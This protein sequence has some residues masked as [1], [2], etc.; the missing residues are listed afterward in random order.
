MNKNF[1]EFQLLG[2]LNVDTTIRLFGEW[3]KGW[4]TIAAD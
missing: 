2:Q 3:S 1:E 4:Q